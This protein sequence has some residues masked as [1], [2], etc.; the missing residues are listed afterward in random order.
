MSCYMTQ[1]KSRLTQ[2]VWFVFSGCQ[3]A[4]ILHNIY[5][6]YKYLIYVSHDQP[7]NPRLSCFHEDVLQL[8]IF[9][10]EAGFSF[11]KI[12]PLRYFI[13]NASRSFNKKHVRSFSSK[14][15]W[16]IESLF[17]SWSVQSSSSPTT[18]RRDVG[19]WKLWHLQPYRKVASYWVL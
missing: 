11:K 5:I 18:R 9:V 19:I 1:G 13:S 6:A 16:G 8:A 10:S 4:N 3:C 7:V 14:M 15:S 17:A 12:Y 2:P